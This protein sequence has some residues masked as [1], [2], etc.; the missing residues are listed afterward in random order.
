MNRS[1]QS[2]TYC[3][4]C[5]AAHESTARFCPACGV[6]LDAGLRR[7]PGRTA[8]VAGL[9][10]LALGATGVAAAQFFGR[11]TPPS[12]ASSSASSSSASSTPTSTAS[13]SP[14]AEVAADFAQIFSRVRSGVVRIDASTC[15]GGGVGTG[16]LVDGDLIVTAAHVVDGAA[17]LGLTLGDESEPTF[18]SGVV[19]GIDRAADVAM[20]RADRN[21]DGHVF[22]F[23]DTAPEVGQEIV[24]IGFPQGEPMT[25]TRGVVSGL[26]RTVTFEDRTAEGLI[27]TDAAIN[28][29]NSGGP[30]VD[31]DG[32]VQG[33]ADAV[34][35]D[36]QGIAYA[37]PAD[38]AQ[39]LADAWRGQNDSVVSAP[40]QEPTAPD[41]T[42]DLDLIPPS[43][44]PL[45]LEVTTFF[46]DYFT[47]I[48][49]SDYERVWTMMSPQ[50]RPDDAEQLAESLSSTI[51]FGMEVHAV[52][53]AS[54]DTVR[55]HVSFISTQAPDQG[56]QGQT[57]TEWNMDYTLVP[58]DDQ[59]QIRR[60]SGHDGQPPYRSC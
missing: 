27:Q 4:N 52:E 39:D 21:L 49:D 60:A 14:T 6:P 40:C 35:T 36:S 48:N 8:L 37:V 45:T 41:T 56:P 24:A 59:W 57:C 38:T 51:D 30:M 29:G 34:R 11:D 25:L 44:D 13:S 46:T 9:A 53:R 50:V 33:V 31:L 15:E 23:S 26:N 1:D 32:S 55:A 10:V 16:F 3:S 18:A 54:D 58:A 19:V 28:P 43:E 2:M 12:T 22:G 47:A 17:S 42:T 5:G 20:I 7:R